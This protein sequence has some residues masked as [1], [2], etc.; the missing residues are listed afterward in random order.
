MT[1]TL[2]AP[3]EQGA[4]EVE[5]EEAPKKR[6]RTRDFSKSTEYYDQ[7]A[8]FVNSNEDFT[9][10]GIDAVSPLQIKAILALRTDF[11]NL[12]EQIALREQSKAERE[13]EKKK[14]EGMSEDQIKAAK[15]AARAEKQVAKFQAKA[16][17]ALQRAEQLKAAASGSAED[18]AAV[19]AS[20]QSE[21]ETENEGEPKKRR[22]L[23]R[24]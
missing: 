21:A 24:S 6:G 7:L 15:A 4:D 19:V 17:E 11:A 18:L 12:P 23:R 13:A 1:D 2:E 9:K 5:T 16:Q 14:Y 20:S 10:A 8:E 22:G 3:V